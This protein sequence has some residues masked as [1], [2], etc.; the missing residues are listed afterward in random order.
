MAFSERALNSALFFE[1][2]IYLLKELQDQAE[3]IVLDGN[4]DRQSGNISRSLSV[5]R[6]KAAL[7]HNSVFRVYFEMFFFT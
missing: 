7:S 4:V 2:R 1:V 3:L 5:S 6:H